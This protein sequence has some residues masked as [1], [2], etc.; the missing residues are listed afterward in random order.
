MVT[1]GFLLAV[2][3]FGR[4]AWAGAG[5]PALIMWACLLGLLGQVIP[6]LMFGIGIPRI[7]S[8]LAALIGALELPVA[9][10][11]SWLIRGESQGVWQLSGIGIILGGIVL[12]QRLPA[13]E[14]LEE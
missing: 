12:A 9:A 13:K 11:A 14:R 2:L 8:G 3:L 4:E 6:T 1:S 7:G 5:E 10:G